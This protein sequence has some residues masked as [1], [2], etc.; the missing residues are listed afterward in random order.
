MAGGDAICKTQC[1]RNKLPLDGCAAA[2][3]P[4]LCQRVLW[5]AC[6]PLLAGTL[7]DLTMR[8]STDEFPSILMHPSTFQPNLQATQTIE[9]LIKMVPQKYQAY[10]SFCDTD[11]VAFADW[12]VR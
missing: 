10:V 1:R 6:P 8:L 9:R 12:C 5:R 7:R 4:P 2:C 11:V 3:M